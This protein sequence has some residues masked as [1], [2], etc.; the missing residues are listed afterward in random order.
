MPSLA[1]MKIKGHAFLTV[2]AG[3]AHA[4]GVVQVTRACKARLFTYFRLTRT[5]LTMAFPFPRLRQ[6]D[7]VAFTGG[8]GLMHSS[9]HPINPPDC[10]MLTS[11]S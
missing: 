9:I 1:D 11:F 3:V 5:R 2:D 4:L 8:P 6:C 7:D 10:I